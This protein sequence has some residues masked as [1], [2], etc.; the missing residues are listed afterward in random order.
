M[1]SRRASNTV[2]TFTGDSTSDD[3]AASDTFTDVESLIDEAF[4]P[5]EETLNKMETQLLDARDSLKEAKQQSFAAMKA[6]A[7]AHAEGA[8]Q[9]VKA[10]EKEAGRKVLADLYVA[11][12]EDETMFSDEQLADLSFEDVDF[13]SSEMAPPFLN[14]DQCLVPGEPVCRVEKAPEN[15]RRIFAGIDI[16]HSVD[17]VWN[18]LTD[19]A[20]L[21]DVVPN[22]VVNDVL[23]E[24][25]TDFNPDVVVLPDD[26]K[27][28]QVRCKEI[29]E[30]MKGS[31]LRQ[32]GG[33]KVAG[34]R[35]SARTTL[36]VR[37][38]PQGLPDIGH[39]NDEMFD[40]KSRNERADDY[41]T[42]KLKRYKFP[43]PF[44][45][46]KLPS[47]DITMQSI[48]GDNGE[49]RMYQGVWRMQPLPGCSPPG[50]DAMRL[51]YAVEVSPRAYLPVQLVERRIVTDLC[52]NLVAIRDFLAARKVNSSIKNK[53][54]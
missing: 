19:Y 28:E 27:P 43:R 39:F 13:M 15:S 18:L 36:D 7:I 38:W 9:A 41:T 54:T 4:L 11:A 6:V 42:T 45:L 16:P 40:G 1:K 26:S 5:L 48:E 31:K 29:A 52:A 51:T 10:A 2:K 14:D 50:Q 46:S 8:V 17:D 53:I 34:I 12:Q 23:A 22:L 47:R 24:Y 44:A 33:A 3:I 21:Q 25:N 49:F 30:Q 37:E 35:F 32:V 20:H